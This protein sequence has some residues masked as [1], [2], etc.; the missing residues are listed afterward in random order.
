MRS[1]LCRLNSVKSTYLLQQW[2]DA[3]IRGR[4]GE[5]PPAMKARA[6]RTNELLVELV[7]RPAQEEPAAE[8]TPATH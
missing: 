5:R 7:R 8:S 2:N 4:I 6:S 3:W 1:F